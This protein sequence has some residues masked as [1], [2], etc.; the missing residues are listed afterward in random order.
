MK[1]IIFNITCIT[2]VIA[3]IACNSNN[4]KNE[5]NTSPTIQSEKTVVAKN[6]TVATTPT[7]PITAAVSIATGE[8]G[9]TL[10][11]TEKTIVA[12]DPNKTE[13]KKISSGGPDAAESLSDN[14][15]YMDETLTSAK[16]MGLKIVKTEKDVIVFIGQ[17]NKRTVWKRGANYEYWGVLAFT[18]AKAPSKIEIVMSKESLEKYFK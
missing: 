12:H 13:S 5:T 9:D 4:K 8:I 18:P 6:D 1:K 14:L 16:K 11:V 10:F 17:N 3:T 2:L 15:H 7:T